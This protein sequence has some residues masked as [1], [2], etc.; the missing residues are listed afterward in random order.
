M[1]GNNLRKT[2]DGL[3]LVHVLTKNPSET[4]GL[5]QIHKLRKFPGFFLV[6][7]VATFFSKKIEAQLFLKMFQIST[8]S[9]MSKDTT[10]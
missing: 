5:E 2:S 8:T 6:V 4:N 9:P 1:E 3:N 10:I 7:G